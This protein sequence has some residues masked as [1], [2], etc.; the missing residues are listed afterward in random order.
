MIALASVLALLGTGHV[1]EV[2]AEILRTTT[3]REAQEHLNFP[4][5]YRGPDGFLAMSCS[6]GVHTKTER[7]MVLVSADDGETWASPERSPVNGM[8]TLLRDGRAVT[9]SCWGPQPNDDGSYPAKTLF[10][11]EGGRALAEQVPGIIVLPFRMSPHFHRSIVEMPDGTLLAT[12]YGKQEG[13]AKYTSALIKTQDRGAR[14]EFLSV[15]A[16]SEEVGKEGFCEP[17][18]V[19]LANGDLLCALRVGGPLYTTR[20]TD[21]GK[22]WSP[23]EIVADHGVDP[24][25][26]LMSNGVLALCY[27]RPDVELLFSADGTGNAWGPPLSLYRGPGC[28]YTSLVEGMNG[29]LLVFFSQSGFCGTE[30]IGPLHM[31]RLARLAVRCP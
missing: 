31:I 13:H 9:L 27:G 1:G 14:W 21:D 15:I 16:Q 19:R 18:L 28:H 30:G 24:A 29:D 11:G 25:L 20:S 17:A 26:L 8:G 3:V 7:G 5:V 12:L 22:T 2:S 4:F 10:Y 6:T 23:P